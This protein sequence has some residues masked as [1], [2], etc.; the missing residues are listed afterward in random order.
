MHNTD[1]PKENILKIV[2]ILF[3][4]FFA[5]LTAQA[6]SG[7]SLTLGPVIE[8]GSGTDHR[9]P[10]YGAFGIAK[11]SAKRVDVVGTFQYLKEGKTYIGNG[12]TMSGRG[13]VTPWLSRSIG[14]DAWAGLTNQSNTA[15]KETASNVGFGP[16]FRTLAGKNPLEIYGGFYHSQAGPKRQNGGYGGFEL[17]K[18]VTKSLGIFFQAEVA[19]GKFNQPYT[20]PQ[21]TG[22]TAS[23]ILIRVGPSFLVRHNN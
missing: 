7:N 5:T 2:V 21:I 10:S 18:L 12:Y 14:I 15:Y 11:V 13:R 8:A 9:N 3:V 22:L 20:T 23:R 19:A 16:R 17:T 1:N 6:Q 4:L